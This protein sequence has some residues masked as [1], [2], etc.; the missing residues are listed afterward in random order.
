MYSVM[1]DSRIKLVIYLKVSQL[2]REEMS[3]IKYHHVVD[4]LKRHKWEKS[5]PF[6]FHE[7]TNDIISITAEEII[8]FL[9]QQRSVD[10]A[11]YRNDSF[12]NMFE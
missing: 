5:L 1:R 11:Q 12:R 8:A 9:A 10:S 3:S 2:S 4:Y 6:S 7:A